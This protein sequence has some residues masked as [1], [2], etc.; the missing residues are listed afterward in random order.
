M[1]KVWLLFRED[2]LDYPSFPSIEVYA[3]ERLAESERIRQGKER[4][5]GYAFSVEEYDV[6]EEAE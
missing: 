3:T 1:T 2:L 5:D 4:G 6:Q